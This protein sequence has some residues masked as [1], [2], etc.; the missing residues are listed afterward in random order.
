MLRVEMK[1]KRYNLLGL[2]ALITKR[3]FQSILYQ[4]LY[5]PNIHLHAQRM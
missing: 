5:T 4:V 1:A 3:P 2:C